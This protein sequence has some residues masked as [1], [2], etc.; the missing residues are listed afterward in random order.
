MLQCKTAFAQYLCCMQCDA[1]LILFDHLLSDRDAAVEF[2][3][4]TLL[5][6]AST[7]KGTILT[8]PCS[9]THAPLSLHSRSSDSCPDSL[10]LTFLSAFTLESADIELT[11][12]PTPQIT[13][14]GA[15]SLLCHTASLTPMPLAPTCDSYDPAHL[16]TNIETH[17]PQLCSS[18]WYHGPPVLCCSGAHARHCREKM[19]SPGSALLTLTLTLNG[20]AAQL[21]DLFNALPSQFVRPCTPSPSPC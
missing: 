3:N 16:I 1:G 2:M 13:V 10:R 4:R 12:S 7:A 19:R 17:I 5:W 21:A 18:Q 8:L 14:N 9:R 15:S 20:S 11:C 6:D